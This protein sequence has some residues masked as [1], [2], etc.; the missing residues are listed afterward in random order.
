MCIR[1]RLYWRYEMWLRLRESELASVTGGNGAIYATRREAYVVV[2]A[3][4]GHDLSF[5]FTMVKNGWR[6]VYAPAARAAEKM[7]PSIEGELARKRRMMSHAWPIVL[8]GGLLDPRGYTPL[9]ALMI[10]S[11]RLLRYAAPALHGGVLAA[12]ARL[13]LRDPR[14]LAAAAL[15]A[16]LG[17]LA[18]AVAGARVRSRPLLVARYYVLTNAAVA[19]GLWDHLRHGT[20]AG[21]TP[22]QGTR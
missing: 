20:P 11:H 2:D 15:A 10:V 8:R 9:Y 18:A 13:A 21:W 14:G 19:A 6:A 3:V 1:D 5:P 4:M 16:Q 7:V 17:L 22:P 12:S